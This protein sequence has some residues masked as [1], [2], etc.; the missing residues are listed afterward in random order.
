[1]KWKA[2]TLLRVVAMAFVWV[3]S[4]S[5]AHAGGYG[6]YLESE[7]SNSKIDDHGLDR[8]FDAEMWG[9]GFMYDGNIAVDELLNYRLNI[10]YR[11][12]RRDL[13]EQP[14]ETVHGLTM[15]NT[16]GLG[17]FRNSRFRVWAG[18]SV[19]LSFDWYESPG[20]VDIVDVAIGIGP[21]LG[22]NVHLTDTISVTSSVAYHY[23]YLSELI[24]SNGINRT[25]D[26]P[27]HMVGVRIGVLWRGEDDI[28]ED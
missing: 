12:G 18:P 4:G 24:E 2:V 14:N 22:V 10:G 5:A 27:Q 1:M 17:F 9:L 20:D 11:V 26:G 16:L 21:R 28:W 15:D 19:R 6:G 25:V 23:M 7:I 13:D 8:G 3:A